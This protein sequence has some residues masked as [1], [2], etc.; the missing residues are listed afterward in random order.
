MNQEHAHEEQVSKRQFNWTAAA[1]A[2]ATAFFA[3]QAYVF[4]S[5]KECV[6]HFDFNLMF[7]WVGIALFFDW[8]FWLPLG[9]MFGLLVGRH[10][11]HK[12][13]LAYVLLTVI[14]ITAPVAVFATTFSSTAYTTN[15]YACAI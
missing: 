4:A 6:T 10:I 8:I 15:P 7:G 2:C 13:P 5:D 1:F 11:P 12:S 9:V 3:V 14:L